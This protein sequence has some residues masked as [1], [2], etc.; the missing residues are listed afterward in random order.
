MD[1]QTKPEDP[2]GFGGG[3]RDTRLIERAIR[4][5]WPIPDDLRVKLPEQLRLILDNPETSPRNKIAAARALLQADVLNLEQEK[6]D[7]PEQPAPG[8]S[9]E[10]PLHV[11]NTHTLAPEAL[12]AFAID[13][14]A[15]GLGDVPAGLGDVPANGGQQPVDQEGTNNSA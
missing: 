6:R 7:K 10:N 14:A 2:T 12:R 9:P 3:A 11:S 5:R 4:Q 8:S 15:A 13:C 1:E